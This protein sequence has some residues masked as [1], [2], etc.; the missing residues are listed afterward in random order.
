MI[1]IFIALALQ[2]TA[3]SAQYES[4]VARISVKRD[5]MNRGFVLEHACAHV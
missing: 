4:D 2:P 5:K 3:T 1:A